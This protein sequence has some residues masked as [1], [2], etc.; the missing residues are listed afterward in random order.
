MTACESKLHW[1]VGTCVHPHARKEN[2]WPDLGSYKRKQTDA[3]LF[4]MWS[5][6]HKYARNNDQLSSAELPSLTRFVCYQRDQRTFE[7]AY[8]LERP[9]EHQYLRLDCSHPWHTHQLLGW[10][11]CSLLVHSSVASSVEYAAGQRQMPGLSGCRSPLITGL[12]NLSTEPHHTIST[13]D[14]LHKD[15]VF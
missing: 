11:V 4:E 2:L 8:R 15:Q 9:Q 5:V 7:L 12:S 3:R 14:F 10:R 6:T 1:P 13:S